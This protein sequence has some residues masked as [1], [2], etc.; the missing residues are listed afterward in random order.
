LPLKKT[1][2]LVVKECQNL[3]PAVFFFVEQA[4]SKRQIA[5]SAMY[6]FAGFT[7]SF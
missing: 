6:I 5:R 3:E 7:L 2:Y 4:G 1:L